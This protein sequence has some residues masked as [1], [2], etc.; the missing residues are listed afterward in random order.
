MCRFV[1][2]SSVNFVTVTGLIF[3]FIPDENEFHARNCP[4]SG[5][6]QTAIKCSKLTIKTIE[7]GVKYVQS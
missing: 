3:R 7:Q 1:Q 6:T 2:C 4:Q 5:T